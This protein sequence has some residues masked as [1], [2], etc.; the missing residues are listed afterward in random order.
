MQHVLPKGFVKVRYYGFLASGCR[1]QL[2]AL[3]QQ[4]G[5]PAAD[6]PPSPEVDGGDGQ[7]AGQGSSDIAASSHVV[8]CPSCG[9][10][11]RVP[12]RVLVAGLVAGLCSDGQFVPANNVPGGA[13][14]L[15][16]RRR[17]VS[18]GI[19][20]ILIQRRRL[21]VSSVLIPACL[22][23]E[24]HDVSATRRTFH[25]QVLPSLQPPTGMESSH[26]SPYLA[27]LG[28]NLPQCPDDERGSP[29]SVLP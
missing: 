19:Q 26:T 28:Q 3:R 15:D 24:K 21:M 25:P 16:E 14:P 6:Q 20:R 11:P 4:I 17:E 8:L 13:V 10:P 23:T 5:C 2:A 18:Q 9:R 12:P 1:Q 7:N 27:F 29:K 22:V